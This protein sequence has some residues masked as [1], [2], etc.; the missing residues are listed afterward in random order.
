MCLDISLLAYTLY[1]SFCTSWN[2]ATIFFQTL[3]KFST[4][5]S[6][7]IFLCHFSFV[8][9]SGTPIIQMLVC[10]L[11]SQKSSETVLITLLIYIFILFHSRDFHHPV[12]GHLSILLP[13][14]FCY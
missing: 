4:T 12:S 1:E 6:S 11:F 2:W 10:F 7:S 13:Q 3:G 9:S 5:I 8:S 14:V